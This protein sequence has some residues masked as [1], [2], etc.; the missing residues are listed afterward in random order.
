MLKLVNIFGIDE[1]EL[2]IKQVPVKPWVRREFL[3]N[4]TH[5]LLGENDNV[6]ELNYGYR[7]SSALVAMAYGCKAD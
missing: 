3:V 2:Y 4:F 7:P 1:I 5:L 6:E